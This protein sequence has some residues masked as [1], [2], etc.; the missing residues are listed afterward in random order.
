MKQAFFL[1]V[2]III[3]FA[4]TN[5][6]LNYVESK[7]NK[8]FNYPYYLFIPENIVTNDSLYIVVETNN[9]GFV[10]DN[11]NKHKKSAK[12]LINNE[13][14]IGVYV[15]R[16]LNYPML[17][18]IFPRSETDWKIYT[19]ALDKDAVIQKNNELE[20]ID[21]QLLNMIE[22]AKS[23]L[24]GLGVKPKGKIILTGF[25]ASGTFANR[26][27]AIHPNKVEIMAAGGLNGILFLPMDSIKNERLNYPIGTNDFQKLF[28]KAFDSIAFQATP[29][30]L[31]MGKKDDNDAI[32]YA[33]AYDKD[34]RDLIYRVIGKDMQ[35][36]RWPNCLEVYKN[37]R[38][39]AKIKSYD[40]IGHGYDENIRKE[41][42]A[43]IKL[44][45]NK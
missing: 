28:R 10:S 22:D 36:E 1:I 5:N 32:Q 21:L 19:H 9:S 29:Q 27:T 26:F 25:S 31:F 12:K 39:N 44:H 4:C 42:L 45:L 14:N 13:E 33:D 17:V 20:R 2:S 18:P 43:F 30:F 34:E 40:E 8:G 11:F 3:F 38:I 6:E 16:G 41:I 24:K 7:P 37:K 35:S 23:T 15:S